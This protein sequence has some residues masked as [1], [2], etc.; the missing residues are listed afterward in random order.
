MIR[1]A[2]PL[3]LA[4]ALAAVHA[5]AAGRLEL[6]L[7]APQD[8]FVL[9]EPAAV[10]ARLANV[11][12]EPIQAPRHLEPEYGAVSYDIAGPVTRRYAP[13]AIKDPAE[14]YV[15]LAP[16]GSWSRAS[17]CSTARKAGPSASLATTRSRRSPPAL[18]P[19][20]PCR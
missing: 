9:G 6:S 16:G 20:R 13:W 1:F 18:P 7:T 11:G 10:L 12:D 4:A 17:I 3:A 2:L 14:P 8:S 19:P 15:M 5:E